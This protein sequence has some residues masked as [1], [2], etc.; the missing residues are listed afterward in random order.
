MSLFGSLVVI[1]NLSVPTSRGHLPSTGENNKDY[2][3][4]SEPEKFRFKVLN[5]LKAH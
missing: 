4:S 2:M 1:D 3:T 5:K